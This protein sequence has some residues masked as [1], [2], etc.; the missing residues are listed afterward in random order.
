[1]TT[2]CIVKFVIIILI[3]LISI[4]F[5]LPLLCKGNSK[6]VSLKSDALNLN[7]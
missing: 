5:I 7:H 1:M 3:T 4:M 2:Y 6:Q